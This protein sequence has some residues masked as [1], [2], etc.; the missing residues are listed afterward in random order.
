MVQS[1]KKGGIIYCGVPDKR[2]TAD[3]QRKGHSLSHIIKDFKKD[4]KEHDPSY[5]QENIDKLDYVMVPHW[6]KKQYTRTLRTNP[7]GHIHYHAWKKRDLK[8]IFKYVG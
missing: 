4:V 1:I 7:I 8:K 6:T 3:H 5:V 2:F